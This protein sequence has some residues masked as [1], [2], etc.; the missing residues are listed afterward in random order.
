MNLCTF[1]LSSFDLIF[2]SQQ[3][4][5]FLLRLRYFL[6]LS[7]GSLA[8]ATVF[9]I[10]RELPGCHIAR[11]CITLSAC[12]TRLSFSTFYIITRY[13]YLKHRSCCIYLHTYVNEYRCLR[14]ECRHV[15]IDIDRDIYILFEKNSLKLDSS[16]YLCLL[17]LRG[18]QLWVPD[19]EPEKFIFH[20][21]KKSSFAACAV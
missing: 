17:E 1:W 21:F 13:D 15:D 10:M 8:S 6:G 5:F 2:Y 20:L 4:D 11:Y 7:K 14:H 18:S 19:L 3:L 9:V 12:S 16:V